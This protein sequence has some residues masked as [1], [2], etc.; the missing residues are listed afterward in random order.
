MSDVDVVV[1]KYLAAWNER[2]PAARRTALADCCADTVRYVDPLAEVEGLD[3]L[4]A[5]I[6]A[7]Q[8]QF[9]GFVFTLLGA[10]DAHHNQAR[11]GWELAPPGRPAPVAGFDV[12]VFAPDGRIQTVLGFLDRM[13]GA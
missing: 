2:D 7:A 8:E 10:I 3:A 11:F 5:A 13:P 6:G 9:P 12:V 1:E 4:D